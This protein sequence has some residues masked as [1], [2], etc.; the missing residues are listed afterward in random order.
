M[1]KIFLRDLYIDTIIG[2]YE[3][4]RHTHQTLKFD[5]EMDFDIRPAARTDAI[6]ETLDYGAISEDI[7]QFVEKSRYQLIETLA[8]TLAERLLKN[9]PIPR[10]KMT[11][12]K[13]V[14]LHGHNRAQIVIERSRS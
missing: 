14:A 6:G 10:L 11:L 4:E 7:V 1:D 13:P 8:E 2:V 9:F 12:T 5:L 3:W